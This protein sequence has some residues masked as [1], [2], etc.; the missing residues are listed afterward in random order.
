MCCE[1][2]GMLKL[3]GILVRLFRIKVFVF[4]NRKGLFLGSVFRVLILLL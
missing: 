2:L 4:R 1:V 3:K